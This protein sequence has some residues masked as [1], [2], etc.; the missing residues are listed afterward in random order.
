MKTQRILSVSCVLAS[1]LALNQNAAA[2]T[3]RT[4][5]NKELLL[6]EERQIAKTT[7]QLISRSGLS[8]CNKILGGDK[9]LFLIDTD[10]SVGVMKGSPEP[11]K[12]DIWY[13][14]V[15]DKAVVNIGS[16]VLEEAAEPAVPDEF[17]LDQNYPNPFNPSTTLKFRIP[18][19]HGS[20]SVRTVLRIY[21]ILGR[22]VRTVVDEELAPGFYAR[23]WDGLNNDGMRTSSGVY[24]YRIRAG[25]F[26]ETKKMMMIK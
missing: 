24:F 19:K 11:G 3:D 16:V 4:S 9:E 2:Q 8:K 23:Q 14:A 26:T 20:K 10:K 17:S 5:P 1:C 7:R 13:V 25:D 21:D 18:A 15:T 6:N 12:S 22:L